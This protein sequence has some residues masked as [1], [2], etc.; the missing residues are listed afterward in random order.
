VLAVVLTVVG[1]YGMLSYAV[2][3][4]RPEIGVRIAL[5][6]LRP[7]V[8]GLVM[9]EAG[10]LLVSG[11]IVGTLFSLVAGRTVSTLLF[12]VKSNDPVTLVVACLLLAMI[13]AVASFPARRASR[14]DPAQMLREG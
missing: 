9:R 5:G 1:L 2:A 11:V 6:A 12:G 7:H 3:Q 14:V 8:I 10:W 4:R 13:A